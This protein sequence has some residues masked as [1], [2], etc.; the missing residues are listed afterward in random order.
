MQRTFVGTLDARIVTSPAAYVGPDGAVDG[1][2]AGRV[3]HE[4]ARA[5]GAGVG[6]LVAVEAADADLPG[7]A[8]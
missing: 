4:S 2:P 6:D 3:G 1:R 7:R 8:G 5:V